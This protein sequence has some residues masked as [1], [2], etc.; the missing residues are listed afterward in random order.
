MIAGKTRE[1]CG[2]YN[3]DSTSIRRPFATGVRLF[4]NVPVT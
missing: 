1:L 2:D 4:I 3:Y